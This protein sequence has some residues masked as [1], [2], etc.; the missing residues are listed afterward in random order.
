[1]ISL[2]QVFPPQHSAQDFPGSTV[3]NPF[4]QPT[5]DLALPQAPQRF[6]DILGSD[7]LPPTP[8]NELD[9]Q[10]SSDDSDEDMDREDN[11]EVN[12]PEEANKKPKAIVNNSIVSLYLLPILH[13]H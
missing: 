13:Y 10:W 2:S 12:M 4:W 5:V 7:A 3:A 8:D 9:D 1:M 6:E 11:V